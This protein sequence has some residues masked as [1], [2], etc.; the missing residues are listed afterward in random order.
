M[1]SKEYRRSQLEP[2]RFVTSEDE[3]SVTHRTGN[4]NRFFRSFNHCGEQVRVLMALFAPSDI[5]QDDGLLF[6]CFKT[7]KSESTSIDVVFGFIARS[8]T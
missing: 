5:F 3:P 8:K 2:S 4:Y 6:Y 7:W 1:I